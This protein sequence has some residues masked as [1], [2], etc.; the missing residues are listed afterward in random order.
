MGKKAKHVKADIDSEENRQLVI[1]AD[2]YARKC[3]L[4]RDEAIKII[5]SAK[6]RFE[7]RPGKKDR[8]R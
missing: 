4:T 5:I 1:E 7:G 2:F 6:R 3:G 8:G